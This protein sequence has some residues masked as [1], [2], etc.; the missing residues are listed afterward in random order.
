M[1]QAS[2]QIILQLLTPRYHKSQAFK[3][4]HYFSPT[5]FASAAG[6]LVIAIHDQVHKPAPIKAAAVDAHVNPRTVVPNETLLILIEELL[7]LS[8]G[9]VSCRSECLSVVI[10]AV[11]TDDATST[12]MN[13]NCLPSLLALPR[14]KAEMPK[15]TT[16]HPNPTILATRRPT[17]GIV[18]I[19]EKKQNSAV[20]T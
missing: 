6:C 19:I 8:L 13:V 17:A 1:N 16:E 3:Y 12:Q 5:I 18:Q 20:N 7:N 15:L 11:M 14:S 10:C 9:N 4:S 2:F